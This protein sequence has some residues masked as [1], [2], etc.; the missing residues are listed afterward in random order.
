MKKVVSG[1]VSESGEIYLIDPY[2]IDFF[3]LILHCFR[4][5][6]PISHILRKYLIS[7]LRGNFPKYLHCVA[8]C[9]IFCL[10]S[11]VGIFHSKMPHARFFFDFFQVWVGQ[12]Q[13]LMVF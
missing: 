12:T 8:K 2:I 9:Y 11:F 4:E 1:K 10:R 5:N 6:A 3:L 13:L 7:I